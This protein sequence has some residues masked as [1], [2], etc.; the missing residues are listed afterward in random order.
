M[1]L[2]V[3][4]SFETPEGVSIQNVYVRIV[5]YTVDVGTVTTIK[6]EAYV[7]REKR[8]E[9]RRPLRVPNLSE[10][11]S[12]PYSGVPDFTSLYTTLKSSFE[13]AGFTVEDVLEDPL[14][15]QPVEETTTVP[16]ASTSL[17]S[18]E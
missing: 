2:L 5:S 13:V 18:S 1:G 14:P 10:Q 4:T 16:E 9:G 17:Q 11:I 12:V 8:L 3:Y 7:N 6:S 15:T